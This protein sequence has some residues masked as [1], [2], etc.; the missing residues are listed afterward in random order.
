MYIT[1]IYWADIINILMRSPMIKRGGRVLLKNSPGINSIR[2][3]W[4]FSM[5]LGG[6]QA[7]RNHINGVANVHDNYNTPKK[8]VQYVNKT[9]SLKGS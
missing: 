6:N 1:T 7:S 5:K 4:C 8:Y 3:T 2:A 9:S